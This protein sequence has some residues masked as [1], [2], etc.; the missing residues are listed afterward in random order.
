MGLEV[1]C[2]DIGNARF[3]NWAEFDLECIHYLARD[4]VLDRKDVIQVT[5]VISPEVRAAGSVNQLRS[6]PDPIA[7]PPDR[8]LQDRPYPELAPDRAHVEAFA[9][10]SK[11]RIARNH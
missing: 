8:A 5:V 4:L 6:D 9:L 7:S 2:W 3:L 11:A 10:V 1:L